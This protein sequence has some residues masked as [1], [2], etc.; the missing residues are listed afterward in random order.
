[1]LL[2]TELIGLCFTL[3]S[4]SRIENLSTSTPGST[5]QTQLYSDNAAQ[6]SSQHTSPCVTCLRMATIIDDRGEYC[7]A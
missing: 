6:Y 2:Y 7:Y 5:I 1:M 4:I 3:H